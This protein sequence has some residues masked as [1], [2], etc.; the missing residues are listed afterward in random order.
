MLQVMNHKEASCVLYAK[1]VTLD[2]LEHSK[3]CVQTVTSL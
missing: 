2:Q 3:I 1:V